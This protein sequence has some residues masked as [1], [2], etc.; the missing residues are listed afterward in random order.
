M[1]KKHRSHQETSHAPG[2]PMTSAQAPEPAAAAEL[3]GTAAAPVAESPGA[4]AGA[5]VEPAAEALRRVEQEAAE[6]KDRCLRAAAEFE[7]YKKRQLRER[8]ETTVRAQADLIVRVLDTVDDLAR[9]AGL[10]PAQT[11]SQALHEGVGLVERKLLKAL[12]GVGLERVDPAGQPFDPNLHEAVMTLAA[13][14]PEADHTV[15]SVL[16]PGYRLNGTL[17]R[18]ARVAVY[19]WTEPAVE[20]AAQ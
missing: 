10:D 2:S 5:L 18:P 12:E 8:A 13:P 20:E 1:I 19:T 15:G 6:W 4:D 7:N 3:A 17:I 9:V 14:S 16:Q 11:T